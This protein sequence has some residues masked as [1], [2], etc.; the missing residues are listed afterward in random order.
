MQA[1]RDTSTATRLPPSKRGHRHSP[2]PT[3]GHHSA[4]RKVTNFLLIPPRASLFRPPSSWGIALMAFSPGRVCRERAEST[5][6]CR[7]NMQSVHGESVPEGVRGA[8]RESVQALHRESKHGACRRA[9]GVCTQGAWG[10]HE[11]VQQVC[12]QC[13]KTGC[14]ERARER[15]EPMERTHVERAECAQSVRRVRAEC[16]ECPLNL[17]GPCER[18]STECALR[19]CT[20]CAERV[21]AEHARSTRSE[22]AH[23]ICMGRARSMWRVCK[24]RE[25]R[26]CV[27]CLHE[28]HAEC[29]RCVWKACAESGQLSVLRACVRANLQRWRRARVEPAVSVQRMRVVHVGRA[30]TEQLSTLGACTRTQG[31]H[32]LHVQRP[33]VHTRV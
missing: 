3:T 30:S 27:Q 20:E 25:Q 1:S 7:E 22:R 31:A 9:H 19:A 21:C 28:A 11:G 33:C 2:A 32:T 17:H 24:E 29:A 12:T 8:C 5:C 10:R 14:T 16:A 26:G 4:R 13:A 6:V 15:V 18:A 23:R